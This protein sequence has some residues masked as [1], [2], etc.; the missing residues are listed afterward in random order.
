M[1]GLFYKF[2]KLYALYQSI[3]NSMTNK[4]FNFS[5]LIITSNDCYFIPKSFGE[6]KILTKNALLRTNFCSS[7]KLY[8]SDK[9]PV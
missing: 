7:L 4:G 6:L 8:F 9:E 2:N 3:N 1:L 5:Y